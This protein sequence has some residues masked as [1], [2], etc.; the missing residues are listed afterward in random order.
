MKK[1]LFFAAIAL[2]TLAG[3]TDESYVGDQSLLTN[4]GG[5]ISFNMKTP[6]ITRSD[7]STAGKLGNEFVVFGY[8]TTT[9]PTDQVVFDNYVVKWVDNSA[10]TTESNSANWE[11]VSYT[12]KATTPVE[13]SI[14]Y[15]DFGAGSYDFFAYSLGKGDEANHTYATASVMT[16]STYTLSGNGTQL[17]TCY[18]SKKNHIGT[19]P[20][21][22]TQVELN[23]VSFLSKIQLKFFETIPGYAVKDLRFYNADGTKTDSDNDGD[24]DGL[25]PALYGAANSIKKGGL[26][27]ITFSGNDP[28]VTLTSDDG[29]THK[30]DLVF[31]AIS[32][33]VY[34]D[35]YATTLDYHEAASAG[36]FLARES[37]S[38]TST[39][40]I[41][42]LP[43]S[44]GAALTLKMDYTLVSRDGTGENIQVTGKTATIPAAYTKWKP[45]YAYTYIFKITDNE[46]VPITLDAIVTDTQDG[47]QETIT[48]VTNRSITTYAKGTMVTANNEYLTGANIYIIVDNGTTLDVT[49]SGN[50][51][52]YTAGITLES[53]DNPRPAAQGITEETVA[54]ALAHG[55]SVVDANGATL[56]V[57]AS[58]GLSAI[59]EIDDD[60][61]PDGNAISVA[62]AMFTPA[63]PT[64][65]PVPAGA[66]EAGEYYLSADGSRKTTLAAGTVEAGLYWTKT[67]STAGYYVFEFT[68]VSDSNKKYYKVIKVVDKY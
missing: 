11:Y 56:A 55:G 12:S 36:D 48:T 59:T 26:Y 2:T 1:K 22:Q 18:I 27:T 21:A 35:N 47:S 16:N 14:K 8:K 68:D 39:S 53:G 67:A 29:Y 58:A 30:S 64:F 43:N 5:A 37:S 62:G 61:A 23:F 46:L 28:I 32:S 65:T 10:S 41:T 45:N 54:N 33:G 42:A 51:K 13:Q 25:V 20:P 50:A 49:S 60:D 24:K 38:A 4:D 40:Q 9:T 66:V 57:T 7:A 34:L 44:T 6:A 52:L 19:L 3:C 15:W 31:D 63:E 17:G